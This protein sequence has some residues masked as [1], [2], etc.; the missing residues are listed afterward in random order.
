MSNKHKVVWS[1]GMFLRP[2]HFQQQER[3]LQS[4]MQALALSDKPFAWGLTELEFDPDLLQLGKFSLRRA[5]GIFPDGTPFSIPE[6]DPA[7]ATLE[8]PNGI[9]ATEILL[10][11]PMQR[12]GAGDIGSAAET[13]LRYRKGNLS[14]RDN[15]SS[16]GLEADIEVAAL[17][18][19]L[20]FGS[21]DLSGFAVLPLTHLLAHE[22][23]KPVEFDS[24]FIPPLL[25]CG[26][27]GHMTAKLR[28]IL[29]LID[30]RAEALAGRL[31]SSERGTSGAFRDFMYLQLLN[32]L[33]PL[34]AHFCQS[35]HVHPYA[36][37]HQLISF[38]GELAS[39]TDPRMRP[40]ELPEYQHGKLS[41]TF[42]RLFALVRDY[43]STV[44]EQTAMLLELSERKFGIFVAP[45]NDRSQ[46][47]SCTFVLAVKGKLDKAELQRNLPPLL[48]VAPVERIR[49][50]IS[51]QTS[52]IKVRALASEPRQIP[53]F[54]GTVYFELE[55]NGELW[56]MMKKSGG[57]AVHLGMKIPELKLELW[58][59]RTE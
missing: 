48:R 5:A 28:E 27:S 1:E 4:R 2:Q 34:F 29:N 15:S 46:L 50:I 56:E 10:C 42:S 33:Q 37:Y 44:A 11:I 55:Q 53:Y 20:R 8:I 17:N 31:T 40:P 30:L 58:A 13:H 45:I 52:G 36:F 9:R 49:D 51:A 54:A 59:I 21:D 41:A 3:Y 12:P 6:N 16:K 24:T 14:T 32:R 47:D 7:P 25:R 43:L 35:H 38:I 22:P 23:D 57:F 26:A 19:Q 39:F 18:C